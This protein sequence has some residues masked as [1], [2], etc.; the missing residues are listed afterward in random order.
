MDSTVEITPN[1]HA[2][3]AKPQDEVEHPALIIIHEIWGLNDNIKDIAGRF[4]EQG[5]ISLVPDLLSG[6]E[7]GKVVTPELV[8]EM[9]DPVKKDEA[10]KKMRAALAPAQTPEYAKETVQKLEK[11][12][13]FLKNHQGASGKVGVVGFCFGGTYSFSLAADQP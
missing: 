10:Q 2:Y 7:L 6:T 8:A 13:Q 9:Q 4:A 3:L 5:Y 1:L 12:F 11:C